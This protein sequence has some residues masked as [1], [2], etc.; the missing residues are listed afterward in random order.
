MMKRIVKANP[1]KEF[2]VNMLVRTNFD[3]FVVERIVNFLPILN[4]AL[5]IPIPKIPVV[6]VLLLMAFWGLPNLNA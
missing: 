6:S 5:F 4:N 2:F 1:T 3:V